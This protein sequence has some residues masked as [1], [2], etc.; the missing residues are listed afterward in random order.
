MQIYWE[1]NKVIQVLMS[2]YNGK[3]YLREQ[4]DSILAQNCKEKMGVDLKLFIRDDGSKD[5]TQKILDEYAEKYPDKI[6]WYQGENIGV[7]KS[8]FELI[9]KSDV[10]AEYYAFSDQDDYWHKEKLSAGIEQIKSMTNDDVKEPLLYCCS[11]LLV[12]ENLKEID[13]TMTRKEKRA[14]FENAVVENIVTG[15]TIVMNKTLRDMAKAYPPKFTVMHDWW[16]YLLASCYGKVYYDK[17]QYISYRQHGT[18]TVGYNTSKVKEFKDRVKRF[19]GN[20]QN[21]TKQLSEF[22][23]IYKLYKKKEPDNTLFLNDEVKRKIRLAYELVKYSKKVKYIPKRASILK[24]T[25]IYRQRKTDNII[26]QIIL[27][28]GSY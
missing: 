25:G 1:E 8:F 14:S 12:D 2:T 15:C 11:Q 10:K 4:I 21:I 18:N 5:G 28:S 17:N 9:E 23:R 27:L 22:I 26:F 13:N 19:R 6:S 7:I 20:R 16:F 24:K 3:D